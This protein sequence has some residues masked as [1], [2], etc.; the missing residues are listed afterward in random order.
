L[1]RSY[2]TTTTTTYWKTILYLLGYW[3]ICI[4]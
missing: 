4:T 1:V 2:Q 3:Y